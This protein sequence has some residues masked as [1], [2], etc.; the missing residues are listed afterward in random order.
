MKKAMMA[1]AALC[2]AG[3]ASAVNLQ[4][5]TSGDGNSY[6]GKQF[7]GT[8]SVDKAA[9][10]VAFTAN[11]SSLAGQQN[12]EIANVGLWGAGHVHFYMYGDNSSFPSRV[13]VEAKGGGG[14]KWAAS[15]DELPVLQAGEK[16]VLA[17]N[18]ERDRTDSGKVKIVAYVNGVKLFEFKKTEAAADMNFTTNQNSAWTITSTAAYE[19]NLTDEQMQYLYEKGTAVLPEPTALALLALGVAGLALRRKAA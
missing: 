9:Y 4:W 6:S 8:A 10:V 13:G 15:E 16:Y 1:L 7:D 12:V 14:S 2:V 11:V 5:S 3:A 17:V 18:L 19:G